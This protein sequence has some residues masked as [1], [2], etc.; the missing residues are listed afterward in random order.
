MSGWVYSQAVEG[1]FI[2][3]GVGCIL[4][5]LMCARGFQAMAVGGSA[6]VICWWGSGGWAWG[7]GVLVGVGEE[8]ARECRKRMCKE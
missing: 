1:G 2:D 7:W 3:V 4:G 8:V 5:R 6:G